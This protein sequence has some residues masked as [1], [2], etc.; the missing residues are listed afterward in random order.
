MELS[1][2]L[3]S[4]EITDIANENGVGS[5]DSHIAIK[6]DSSIVYFHGG[7]NETSGT[8]RRFD[9]RRKC[10]LSP[11][12]TQDSPPTRYYHGFVFNPKNSTFY[13][14]GG[15][16]EDSP[17]QGHLS[18]ELYSYQLKSNKWNKHDIPI[19]NLMN[20]TN[21]KE[22]EDSLRNR[23]LQIKEIK[24]EKRIIPTNNFRSLW[25]CIRR[26]HNLIYRSVNNSLILFGG[27]NANDMLSDIWEYDIDNSKWHIVFQAN[28][29][30]ARAYASCSYFTS[31]KEIMILFGGDVGNSNQVLT[32][33]ICI[34][35]F[36]SKLWT[37]IIPNEIP[38][39]FGHSCSTINIG[40]Y[41]LIIYGGCNDDYVP[42]SSCYRFN[43]LTYQFSQIEV[44]NG[45]AINCSAMF[46]DEFSKRLFLYGGY[47]TIG[48]CKRWFYI[49]KIN[50][51]TILSHFPKL[52]KVL[53]NFTV[54]TY[55]NDID[56]TLLKENNE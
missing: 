36:Y 7:R 48:R 13:L 31:P 30:K 56:I 10:W 26:G 5:S 21:D 37:I 51:Q 53:K 6:G 29:I 3:S 11:I 12:G 32:N 43:V 45:P 50:L 16:N 24:E 40:P 49:E 52:E 20:I 18:N 22:I 33:E 25:P 27:N 8:I 1:K 28:N 39:I 34:F 38:P 2:T 54:K 35:D 17:N 42:L 47:D 55:F 4:E 41:D 44:D 23:I 14:F 19:D 15:V 46:Y 9:I